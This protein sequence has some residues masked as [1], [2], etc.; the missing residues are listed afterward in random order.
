MGSLCKNMPSKSLSEYPDNLLLLTKALESRE[1]LW[2]AGYVQQPP[3]E[4][5]V[6]GWGVAEDGQLVSGTTVADFSGYA[7]HGA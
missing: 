4:A 1:Y 3:I 2:A 6:F 7:Y 5:V